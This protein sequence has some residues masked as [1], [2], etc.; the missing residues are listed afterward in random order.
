MCVGVLIFAALTCALQPFRTGRTSTPPPDGKGE[1]RKG[2]SV[3]QSRLP[4]KRKH[5]HP[6]KHRPILTNSPVSRHLKNSPVVPRA[7]IAREASKM[8]AGTHHQACRPRSTSWRSTGVHCKSI[9]SA[10][11]SIPRRAS[12]SSTSACAQA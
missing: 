5:R 3:R 2:C 10:Q 7:S 1:E 11:R 9:I 6:A 4:V 8:N 12:G